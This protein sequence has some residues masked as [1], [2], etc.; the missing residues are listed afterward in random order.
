M[1]HALFIGT[2][3]LIFALVEFAFFDCL[4]SRPPL[5]RRRLLLILLGFCP[6]TL[7]M[8]SGHITIAPFWVLILAVQIFRN[9]SGAGASWIIGI[10][11]PVGALHWIWRNRI[12]GRPQ[13]HE[14]RAPMTL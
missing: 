4:A 10:S 14:Y 9:G 6:T 12:C 8:T 5:W 13:D 11:I 1:V 7:D 2:Y 3:L